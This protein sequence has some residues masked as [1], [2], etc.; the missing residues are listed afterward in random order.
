IPVGMGYAE[1]SGLP[2]VTGLHAT[3]AGLVA[4]A[5]LGPSRVRVLGPD[6]SLAPMIG[7]AIGATAVADPDRAVA[8]AG[9]LALLVGGGLVLVALGRPARRTV[10]R[11]S[12]CR[13]GYGRGLAIGV[14]G[15]QVPTVLGVDVDEESL[16]A[17]AGGVVRGLRDGA[18][19]SEAAALGIGALA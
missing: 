1:V 13:I 10:L 8:L 17:A 19:E 3:I 6:S 7:A 18:R 2:P 15:G 16:G 12:T 5:L 14:L 4:Y 9:V 11:A